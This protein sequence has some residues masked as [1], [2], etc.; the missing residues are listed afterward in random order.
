MSTI[1]QTRQQVET[2]LE[3][4][5]EQ[6][7]R[8][9]YRAAHQSLQRISE[10]V[11]DED[12]AFVDEIE[13]YRTLLR[14]LRQETRQNIRDIKQQLDEQLSRNVE[15]FESDVVLELLD[16]WRENILEDQDDD[17]ELLSYNNT[18]NRRRDDARM[19]RIASS[20]DREITQLIQEAERRQNTDRA[21]TPDELLTSYYRRA[22]DIALE[23]SS[24]HKGNHYLEAIAQRAEKAYSDASAQLGIVTTAA[25]DQNYRELM[26]FLR[27]KPAGSLVP[28]YR[29]GEEFLGRRPVEEAIDIMAVEARAF[30]KMKIGEYRDKAEAYLEQQKPQEADEVL[31]QYKTNGLEEFTERN[32]LARVEELETRISTAITE[33]RNAQN[34]V[35]EARTISGTD[36][37]RAYSTY[38]EALRLY[39]GVKHLPETASIYEDIVRR[40]R[41]ELRTAIDDLHTAYDQGELL[42]VIEG[43]R[44][45]NSGYANLD[46][47][48]LELLHEAE[49]LASKAETERKT[50]EDVNGKL[51]EIRRLIAQQEAEST[52]QAEAMLQALQRSYDT[53]ILEGFDDYHELAAAI[54][55]QLHAD[56]ELERLAKFKDKLDLQAVERNLNAA[57]NG[58]DDPRFAEL[59]REL[60]LHL[61]FL[62]AKRDADRR[63]YEEASQKLQVVI[64]GGDLA[65]D[66]AEAEELMATVNAALSNDAELKAFLQQVETYLQED[67]PQLAF[68]YIEDNASINAPRRQDREKLRELKSRAQRG[69]RQQIIEYLNGLSITDEGLSI[70]DIEE[71]L[72]NLEIKLEASRDADL[73]RRRLQGLIA[74]AMARQAMAR[75]DIR[76]ALERWQAARQH[77]RTIQEKEYVDQQINALTRQQMRTRLEKLIEETTDVDRDKLPAVIGQLGTLANELDELSRQWDDTIY[78]VWYLRAQLTRAILTETLDRRRRLFDRIYE[79][80][81]RPELAFEL[82]DPRDERERQH[83]REL[84]SKGQAV[85]DSMNLIEEN[86][87]ATKS[88]EELQNAVDRWKEQLEDYTEYFPVLNNWYES[89]KR[90]A[91]DKLLEEIQDIEAG[92]EVHHLQPLAKLLVLGHPR[93]KSLQGELPALHA[94]LDAQTDRAL[95]DYTTGAGFENV[96]DAREVITRQIDQLKGLQQSHQVVSKILRQFQNT[97]ELRSMA[98]DLERNSQSQK[99][100]LEHALT[101][102]DTLVTN[103]DAALMH[104][105][106][107][108]A[109]QRQASEAVQKMNAILPDHVATRIAQA[110]LNTHQSTLQQLLNKVDELRLAAEREQYQKAHQIIEQLRQDLPLL[111]EYQLHDS[112]GVMDVYQSRQYNHWDD[113]VAMIEERLYA[114]DRVQRWAAPF[115]PDMT[116]GIINCI[117][118]NNADIL[119]MSTDGL[120]PPEVTAEGRKWVVDWGELVEQIDPFI[121]S[122]QFNRARA[123][124]ELAIRGNQ[125]TTMSLERAVELA[126]NPPIIEEH[127]GGLAIS[128][129][130]IPMRYQL[131]TRNAG[132]ACGRKI[133]A[134]VQR[135]CLP[136]YRGWLQE[137]EELLDYITQQERKLD[138][139]ELRFKKGLQRIAAAL[140]NG[141]NK[142]E[143]ETELRQG[144][145]Q[146]QGALNRIQ[147]LCGSHPML[148]HMRNHSIL[149]EAKENMK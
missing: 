26:Q 2:A 53:T 39:Q 19:Y 139:Y 21:V 120:T 149:R 46:P 15:D 30:A 3:Q 135:E 85:A 110:T 48:L 141:G 98:G 100:S 97:M 22:R 127:E 6:R 123:Q 54:N 75:N 34:R 119:A 132:T 136:R 56:A 108:H 89:I 79:A 7:E 55:R 86:L 126:E 63:R 44:T 20:T 14:E 18:I 50:T 138:E 99:D 25:Q 60:E 16:Q 57:R 17:P 51:R 78:L 24:Q 105:S 47:S 32:D 9:R 84:A 133:F 130:D 143:R 73:Y 117:K 81:Q 12:N 66:S 52:R 115:E 42:R 28:V 65:P 88:L 1:E 129:Y 31:R 107:G 147:Q 137:A 41:Q 112:L 144:V 111:E 40:L 29:N 142:R 4:A 90:T 8:Q 13:R 125:S 148:P 87:V 35:Q 62:Q 128:T 43:Y 27:S 134:S 61:F 67:N 114:L 93:G 140:D 103:Y 11:D 106:K 80:A 92:F 37:R 5:I 45:L 33:L 116:P 124:I 10:L 131:A 122:G 96:P 113:V 68:E 36:G 58:S 95:E 74:V 76:T 145:N 59:A 118:T 49:T 77:V 91:T 104:L 109:G 69:W 70:E 71:N 23:A 38:Q 64:E 101:S 82:D 146:A 121:T 83:Q 94:Q 72:E 102:L